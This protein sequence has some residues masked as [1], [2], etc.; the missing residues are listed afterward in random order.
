[1]FV[2]VLT[3]LRLLECLAAFGVLRSLW[4]RTRPSVRRAKA[5]R[6]QFYRE[7]WEDAA[8]R[9]GASVQRL[10]DDLLE[11]RRGDHRVRVF[12]N[13]TPLDDPITLRLA[14]DKV[15]VLRLLEEAGLPV[16]EHLSFRVRTLETA[17]DFLEH[18]EGPCVVKP[19]GGTGAGQG[20]TTG[21]VK[22]SQLVLA[23]TST[24]VLP[25]QPLLI[26]REVPGENYRLLFLDGILL[27]A[28]RRSAPAVIGNGTSSIRQLVRAANDAR[29]E[30]GFE[31]SQ[32]VLE[33]D[34]DLRQ[35]LARQRLKLDQVPALGKKVILKTAINSN[36]AAEN[37]S[38]LSDVA[39]QIVEA[40]ARAARLVGSRLAG[41]DIITPDLTVSL[42]DAGGVILEV[43]T[44]PG[45]HFHYHKRGNPLPVA[46]HVLEAVFATR[47]VHRE[48]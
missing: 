14:G 7:A 6:A 33:I 11:I 30:R 28:V 26:E 32:T 21:I 3:R 45:F 2:K 37:E 34:R 29:L 20:V 41:V 1:M 47:A 19:A 27:D 12:R 42:E 4:R 40:G 16:T 18:A 25:N 5:Q 17:F 39:P 9:Q 36:T 8:K 38:V 13:Y 35:T 31:H 43:N 15:L 10:T 46:E 48:S 23:A 44:T 24:G 22:R